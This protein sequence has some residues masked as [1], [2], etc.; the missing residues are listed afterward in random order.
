MIY[1]HTKGNFV[2]PK[3]QERETTFYYTYNNT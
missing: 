2:P 1:I 3:K